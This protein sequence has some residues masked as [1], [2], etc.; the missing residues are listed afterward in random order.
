M[1]TEGPQYSLFLLFRAPP[2][3]YGHSQARGWI[4]KNYS[5]QP[6]PQ[7]QQRR[8]LTASVTYTAACGNARSLTYWARPGMEPAFSWRLYQVLKP[9]S[10]SR[11]SLPPLPTLHRTLLSQ[12]STCNLRELIL[13]I[14]CLFLP[15]Q[16][17]SPIP[18]CFPGACSLILGCL[19][20]F[21]T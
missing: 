7:P 14:Q 16:L 15:G 4:R 3:A 19:I 21:P 20:I 1:D 11:N 2:V 18:F 10:H 12:H 9:L 5:C 17:P 13:L 6:T 8:I